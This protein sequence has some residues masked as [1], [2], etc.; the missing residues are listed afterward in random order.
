MTMVPASRRM[1]CAETPASVV[2]VTRGECKTLGGKLVG[3]SLGWGNDIRPESARID[4]DFFATTDAAASR[5]LCVL[6]DAIVVA[7]ADPHADAVEALQAR[8][9]PA[10]R[11]SAIGQAL[12]GVAPEA[13]VIAAARAYLAMTPGE[14]MTPGD[15]MKP[16][17]ATAS[18]DA[19]TPSGEMTPSDA[20]TPSGETADSVQ[21]LPQPQLG[22]PCDPRDDHTGRMAAP[23]PLH[24]RWQESPWG[25]VT[26]PEPLAPQRQMD[27]D[28]TLAQRVADGEL[29][30]F[31]RFWRWGGKAIVL[32]AYQSEQ[33]QVNVQAAQREGFHIVRRCTGGGTMVVEPADTIT[34]SLYAPLSFVRGLDPLQA[35]ALCDEWLVHALRDLGVHASHEPVNDIASPAGKIGGGAS[36]RFLACSGTAGGGCFLHHVTLAYDMDAATMVRVLRVSAEKLRGKH[37]ASAAKRVDPLRQQLAAAGNPMTC[38]QATMALRERALALLPGAHAIAAHQIYGATIKENVCTKPDTA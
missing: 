26:D 31:V 21:L 32:G 11:E 25:V 5:A 12:V 18:D 27:L 35:Y 13:V 16:S 1:A 4:G 8:V 24:S 20:M 34:Y 33:A 9:L 29:P 38:A 22:Q 23:A 17:G 6:Q 37:V 28:A 14:A 2:S 30:P 3:V 7:L 36:R 10:W 19:M 15:E